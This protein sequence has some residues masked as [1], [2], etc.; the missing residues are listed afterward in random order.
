MAKEFTYK[1]N[2]DADI[3]NLTSKFKSLKDALSSITSE[4][5]EP[6]LTKMLD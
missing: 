6:K 1:M 2:I 5:K 4:G 3:S